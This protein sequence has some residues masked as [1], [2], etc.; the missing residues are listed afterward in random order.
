MTIPAEFLAK[1]KLICD[2][3]D[4]QRIADEYDFSRQAISNAINSG[5][6]SLEVFNAIKSYYEKREQ[7][8]KIA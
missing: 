6:C 5:E 3:G 8:L 2:H 7:N 4:K 1:W